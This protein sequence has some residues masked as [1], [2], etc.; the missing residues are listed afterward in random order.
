MDSEYKNIA[1][2]T[3]FKSP[4]LIDLTE[5]LASREI[6]EGEVLIKIIS[7]PI[8]PS[9]QMMVEG[10]YG[11]PST[12]HKKEYG[13]GL[14]FE[15]AGEIVKAHDSLPADLVGKKVAFTNGPS[16]PNF[17]GTWRQFIFMKNAE[18]IPFPDD[19]DL[20][21]ICWSIVNPFTA[22][23]F[24][25]Y[26]IK[27]GHKAMIHDAACSS[28]GKMLIKLCKKYSIP[29]INTLKL[30]NKIILNF[31]SFRYIFIK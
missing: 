4:Q 31:L 10:V 6:Q 20:N 15:G 17:Q 8:N 9:D 26:Y 11:N 30:C 25:D 18:I 1:V 23:G 2:V 3:D 5:E 13:Y 12:V 7:A 27:G 22:C 29:L 24:V 14:G 19:S 16:S 21:K 28:L